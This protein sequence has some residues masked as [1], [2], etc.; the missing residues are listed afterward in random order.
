M[1]EKICEEMKVTFL[2]MR[3]VYGTVG[4]GVGGKGGERH[5]S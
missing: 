5:D 2:T 1:R 3:I 4:V